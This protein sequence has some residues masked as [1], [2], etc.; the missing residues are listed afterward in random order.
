MKMNSETNIN[1]IDGLAGLFRY[2]GD[3]DIYRAVSELWN[4][5]PENFPECRS[6]LLDFR[7]LI[8]A[9]SGERLEEIY[10]G[11]F[12]VASETCPYIGY[13]VFGDNFKR[14]EFLVGLKIMFR[15]NGFTD[16]FDLPDHI[17]MLLKFIAGVAETT[18]EVSDL[19]SYAIHPALEKIIASMGNNPAENP[20]IHLWRAVRVI[21]T[22]VAEPIGQVEEVSG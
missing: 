20:Y 12:D 11:A 15:E 8:D 19:V 4:S 22:D 18:P 16:E 14:G 10:I 9:I 13:Q 21:M 17:A 3:F 5:V 2:P 6:E 7:A 1:I